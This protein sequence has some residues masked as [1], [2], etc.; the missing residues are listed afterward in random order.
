MV[1]KPLVDSK[2]PI[3]NPCV[4]T[5]FKLYPGEKYLPIFNINYKYDESE[6]FM[7]YKMNHQTPDNYL[8]GRMLLSSI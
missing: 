5:D 2:G 4:I 3:S 8:T 6:K 7:V 1:R